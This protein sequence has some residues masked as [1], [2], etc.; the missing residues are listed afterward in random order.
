MGCD[1][2]F[3]PPVK[4]GDV[5]SFQGVTRTLVNDSGPRVDTLRFPQDMVLPRWKL[6]E[7]STGQ[8]IRD[9]GVPGQTGPVQMEEKALEPLQ[10][11]RPPLTEF[12]QKLKSLINAYSMENLSGTPDFILAEFLSHCLNAFTLATR[13][14]E[15]WYGR[16]V[17]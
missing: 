15:H 13:A 10:S 16:R 4:R 11:E 7:N 3:D 1:S 8:F 2:Q 6:G 12:E 5:Q 17:F 14:R 9:V